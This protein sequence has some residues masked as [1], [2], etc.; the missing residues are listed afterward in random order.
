ML[1][2]CFTHNMSFT[3]H[4]NIW[5]SHYWWVYPLFRHRHR[6]S[7]GQTWV[8]PTL[9][10]LEPMLSTGLFSHQDTIHASCSHFCALSHVWQTLG[11]PKKLSDGD[12]R[13]IS[14]DHFFTSKPLTTVLRGP[15]GMLATPTCIPELKFLLLFQ[16]QLPINANPK[17]HQT[18]AQVFGALPPTRETYVEVPVPAV[19]PTLALAAAVIWRVD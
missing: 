3:G 18:T 15:P 8:Q 14:H 6:S 5:S 10:A 9:T 12:S 19:L 4:N 7:P 11:K 1:L 17:R 16:F 2:K 13:E